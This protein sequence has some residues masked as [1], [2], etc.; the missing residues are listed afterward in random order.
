MIGQVEWLADSVVDKGADAR[1]GSSLAPGGAGICREVSGGVPA[2]SNAV[3]VPVV[4]REPEVGV[5][6]AANF[7]KGQQLTPRGD[8]AKI[9][10]QLLEHVKAC[11]A[12]HDGDTTYSAE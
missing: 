3:E 4:L 12:S 8:A 2:G 5:C 10:D 7:S 1:E 6:P 9:A 11:H